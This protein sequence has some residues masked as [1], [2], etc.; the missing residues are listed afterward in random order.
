MIVRGEFAYFRQVMVNLISNAIKYTPH[1][2]KITVRLE[3]HG[4]RA[5]FDV[6]DTGYGISEDRQKRLGQR[7][8]RAQEPGTEHIEGTGLG[9]SLVKTIIERSKGNFWFKSEQ[10]KG[11]TF[12]FWLPINEDDIPE[13]AQA[14]TEKAIEDSMFK[15]AAETIA[16]GNST[17]TPSRPTTSNVAIDEDEDT[18]M[19]NVISAH[20]HNGNTPP[21]S[22]P[23]R[24]S[25][26]TTSAN[27]NGKHATTS[28]NTE[29]AASLKSS[30]T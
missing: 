7:F 18:S 8:Y 12:G 5:F 22:T 30:D 15:A 24:T 17:A 6:T 11:S 10:G 16:K 25:D 21:I 4:L 28:S 20:H 1:R 9:L 13:D 19:I 23:S 2:G 29:E 14:F 27:G 3:Q 26:H